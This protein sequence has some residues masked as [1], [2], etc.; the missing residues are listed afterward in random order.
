MPSEKADRAPARLTGEL[1][2]SD[3]EFDL[4]IRLSDHDTEEKREFITSVTCPS[5]ECTTHDYS[6]CK[7]C[8]SV[9]DGSCFD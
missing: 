1:S 3:D 2:M 4:D 9:C 8:K 6:K 5:W 7:T